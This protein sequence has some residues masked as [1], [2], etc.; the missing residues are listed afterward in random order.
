MKTKIL[1]FFI[2]LSL[3]ISFNFTQAQATTATPDLE[4][5]AQTL[6]QQIEDL[7]GRILQLQEELKK[8]T[9]E[10]K[11]VEKVVKFTQNLHKGLKDKE[12][13]YLQE[14]LSEYP[15]IYPEGLVT[16]YF[17]R[18]TENA[19]KKF[20]EKYAD[21]VLKP[22]GLNKGTGYVGEKTIAKINELMAGKKITI[23]HYPPDNPE[24]RHTIVINKSALEAHLTH[25][26]FIGACPDEPIPTPTPT[27]EPEPEDVCPN[28]E[29][30]Q[31]IIPSGLIKNSEGNCVEPEPG[32][33]LGCIDETALNYNFR[34]TQDN[35]TCIYPDTTSPVISNVQALP[36]PY[37]TTAPLFIITWQTNEKSDSVVDYGLTTSYGFTV[38][39]EREVTSHEVY[40][41]S[42]L[43]GGKTYHY[44]V[45]STDEADNK[46]QSTDKTF[47]VL[48]TASPDEVSNFIAIGGDRQISLSWTNPTNEDFA[49]I[50]IIRKSADNPDGI[51]VYTGIGVS[52]IDT[53]NL[54]N[55]IPYYYKAFSYDEDQNY[56]SGVWVYTTPILLPGQF[57]LNWGSYGTDDGQ[58]KHPRGIAIDTS[59]NIYV[60]DPV[61]NRIQKFTSNGIF[62]TKWVSSGYDD[63]RFKDSTRIAIDSSGNIYVTEYNKHRVQK[64]TSDGVFVTNWGS[65]GSGDGQFFIPS[66]IAVDSNDNIYVVDANHRVQKFTSDGIFI[67]KWGS[68]GTDDGQLGS[69]VDIAID[70]NDNV[71]VLETSNSRVQKFTKDGTFIAK[72]GQDSILANSLAV[73]PNNGNIY[74]VDG[75]KNRIQKFTNDGTF[76]TEW[77]S[78]G[79]GYGEFDY[80]NDIVVDASGNIYVLDR[81]NQRI[82]K[83]SSE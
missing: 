58:F 72:W 69:P 32:A 31:T 1:V 48:D 52:Y 17:G 49:G 46:A 44:K 11:E 56:S 62:I 4:T 45:S 67:T 81:R 70:V 66:G 75:Y 73:D 43:I 23:C 33:I 41:S 47:T 28:L 59:G 54:L 5:L 18:L 40:V 76:L 34:A 14:F 13:E 64:F 83:F 3:L 24:N 77:G 82:Q 35:N 50:K 27:P 25:G 53:N 2:C 65:E 38:S 42:N 22:Y 57:L 71:Y 29:G 74:V 55:E 78:K 20:Q 60:T 9:T 68:Y 61:N 79:F 12:V 8:I 63:D 16:G 36:A 51:T 26:D 37:I 15:E 10:F 7:I 21:D 19:V 30:V 80:P 6:R 39:K